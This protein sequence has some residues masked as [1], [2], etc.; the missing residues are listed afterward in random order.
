MWLEIWRVEGEFLQFGCWSCIRLNL[1]SSFKRRGYFFFVATLK[2]VSAVSQTSQISGFHGTS[3]DIRRYPC[4]AQA[5][6]AQNPCEDQAVGIMVAFPSLSS[7]AIGALEGIC[8]R[9][10]LPACAAL[11]AL[12]DQCRLRLCAKRNKKSFPCNPEQPCFGAVMESTPVDFCDCWAEL[13]RAIVVSLPENERYYIT[14]IRGERL[15]EP[16]G[17]PGELMEIPS[18][19]DFPLDVNRVSQ[20]DKSSNGLMPKFPKRNRF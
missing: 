2:W 14:N 19:D 17:L 8:E 10:I 11:A 18:P 12:E 3:R 9:C 20:G 13:L 6:I 4:Q 7:L 15:T 1:F 16:E 5:K